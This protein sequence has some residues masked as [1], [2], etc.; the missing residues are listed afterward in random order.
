MV[1]Q[2]AAAD[3]VFDTRPD[4]AREAMRSI[5]DVGRATLSE[6]RRLLN[7]VRPTDEPPSAPQPGMSRVDELAAVARSA[8]LAVTVTQEGSRRAF[9]PVS[10]CRRTGSCRRP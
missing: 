9:P 8:G 6:L 2:A 7:V 10:T 3:E 5:A 1:V 4:E